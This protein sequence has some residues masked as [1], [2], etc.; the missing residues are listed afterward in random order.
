MLLDFLLDLLSARET[1]QEKQ[2]NAV[3]VYVYNAPIY[4]MIQLN[5]VNDVFDDKI[6]YCM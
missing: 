6:S 1:V 2:F 4:L 5:I 3:H